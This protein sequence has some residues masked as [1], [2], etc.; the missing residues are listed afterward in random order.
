MK[1]VYHPTLDATGQC[2]RCGR[3]LCA[4]CMQGAQATGGCGECLRAQPAASGGPAIGTIVIVGCLVLVLLIAILGVGGYVY[5]K[6]SARDQITPPEPIETPPVPVT[7]PS[8]TDP[9]A[10]IEPGEEAVAVW[11]A[12]RS[13]LTGY[14]WKVSEANEGWTEVRI[15]V[16]PPNSEWLD[17]VDLVWSASGMLYVR[18]DDGPVELDVPDDTGRTQP[19]EDLAKEAALAHIDQPG[20]LTKV[21]DHSGDWS[22]AT[23]WV[24]PPA[25]EWVYRV[26]MRW[27]SGAEGYA[28]EAVE[29]I[30]YP[31]ME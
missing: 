24:G 28:I 12:G 15:L 23:L 3:P 1:C 31:G 13:D 9:S 27:D 19:T 16:G 17:W 26:R 6:R 30:D 22:T 29:P 5:Y 10:A 11:V 7:D 21:T 14:V 20:W 4:T 8:D 2:P 25:S 18:A